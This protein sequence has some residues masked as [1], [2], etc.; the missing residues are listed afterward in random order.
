[1]GSS[2]MAPLAARRSSQEVKPPLCRCTDE[3][4]D[5]TM[6]LAP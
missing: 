4:H 5:A 6:A 2:G 1:M 3:R